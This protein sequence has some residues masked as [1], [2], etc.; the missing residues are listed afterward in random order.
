MRKALVLLGVV[1]GVAV[2]GWVAYATTA[3]MDAVTAASVNA[4]VCPVPVCSSATEDCPSAATCHDGKTAC[5]P[6]CKDCPDFKDSN[7]D[8]VCDVVSDCGRHARSGGGAGPGRCGGHMGYGR[9]CWHS[10]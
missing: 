1:A 4:Q 9:G 7:G 5:P 6:S 3:G 10:R 8:G 2:I